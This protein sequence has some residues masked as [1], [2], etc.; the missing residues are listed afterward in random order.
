MKKL[1]ATGCA[2]LALAAAAPAQA[3]TIYYTDIVTGAVP[4]SPAPWLTAQITDVGG[5]GV[6]VV[7]TSGALSPEFIDSIYF[8]LNGSFTVAD[9]TT[10]PDLDTQTCQGRAPAGTGP[11]QLCFSF[12][13]GDHSFVSPTAISFFVANLSEANFVTNAAG[14]LSVAHVQGI[15]PANC[16][17][18]VGSYQGG[19][20]PNVEPSNTGPCTST[21][22]PEPATLG[23]LGLGLA[24]LGLVR[25]RNVG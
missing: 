13:P 16:S 6:D 25:R 15:E 3:L 2:A 7:L 18:W 1:I 24:G 14:W 23:L 10:T 4:N 5:G 12:G 21:N 8:S 9:P 11:W 19:P 22:V 17:A 20:A